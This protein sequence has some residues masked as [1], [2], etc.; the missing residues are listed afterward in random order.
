[1]I[2]S[3]SNFDKGAKMHAK[4]SPTASVLATPRK[5]ISA[6]P[7]GSSLTYS[8]EKLS[9]N[10]DRIGKISGIMTTSNSK[11]S[12]SQSTAVRASLS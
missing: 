10:I 3:P 11:A 12:F 9:S 1:M 4:K 2:K 8:D 5:P 7:G 6:S